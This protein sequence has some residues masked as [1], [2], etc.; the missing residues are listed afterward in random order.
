[1]SEN[2]RLPIFT[3]VQR[4]GEPMINELKFVGLGRLHSTRTT[5]M[6]RVCGLW[7]V[8]GVET[9]LFQERTNVNTTS[10]QCNKPSTDAKCNTTE[11]G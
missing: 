4:I 9:P 2:R 3:F 11:S 6:E 8:D 1:M 5:W 10:R 7:G